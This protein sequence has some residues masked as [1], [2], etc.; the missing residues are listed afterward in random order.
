LFLTGENIVT[1]NELTIYVFKKE[2][3]ITDKVF[4]EL[5]GGKYT[6]PIDEPYMET[7]YVWEID[8][9]PEIRFWPLRNA[10]PTLKECADNLALNYME[11]ISQQY[12]NNAVNFIFSPPLGPTAKHTSTYFLT[13]S[14]QN[15]FE[16][17]FTASLSYHKKEA[18]RQALWRDIPCAGCRF[19]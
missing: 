9:S 10:L 11:K 7:R 17:E 15:F 5:D 8:Y 12:P 16:D 4:R 19:E 2:T 13:K 3:L 18:Q 14:E 6:R 1:E